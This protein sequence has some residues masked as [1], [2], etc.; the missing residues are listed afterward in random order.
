MIVSCS[1][2]T[3]IP[4][5]YTEWLLGRI[6]EGF[7]LVP[8]PMNRKVVARVSL[9]KSSVDAIVFWS[10]DPAPLLP[11]LGELDRRGLRY[12]FLFTVNDYPD[13]LEPN[14]APLPER[15]ETFKELARRIGPDRVVWRY[16]P[17]I[18]SNLT[19]ASYHL[20]RFARLC[21][22]LAGATQRCIT[23]VV[24]IYRKTRR[25]LA[26]LY[27][28][29]LEADF[30]PEDNPDLPDLLRGMVEA[31]ERFG[32]TVQS[33]AEGERFS[34]WGVR[35]GKCI[36]DELIRRAFGIDAP[37]EKDRNQRPL[38]RCVVSRDIG[39]ND[40]CLRCCPYC[41]ATRSVEAARRNFLLHD[42]SS[43]MLVGRPHPHARIV[44]VPGGGGPSGQM[45][46]D[47]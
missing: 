27:A 39:M 32:I 20:G 46:L 3:D 17:I 11:H 38:C 34:E 41:Y 45:S 7:C 21:E 42:P 43:P 5:F 37:S 4:S 8:N 36:D 13:M 19:P 16:D 23:S 26:A 33:C 12:Y 2:R 14:L 25:G 29:G 6:R 9:D 10:K 28:H 30:A 15:V 18:F 35:P 47:L 44:D 40:T 22:A 24:D 31:A 1:R